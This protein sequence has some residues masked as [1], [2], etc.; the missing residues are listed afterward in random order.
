[1]FIKI[2]NTLIAILYP[3]VIKGY[4]KK[5]LANG[6]ED[7]ARFNERVGRPKMQRPEGKLIWLHG[8]SVGESISM[9]P[10]IQRIL[11][12]YPDAHVMVTTGTVTSADVMSKRLPERAFH[13]FIPIDNPFF[14]TRFIKHWQPNVALWFESELWPAMLSSIKRKNIPLIL[15]NG[16]ISNKSF[17]R[18]QQFD[19]VCKELLSCFTFCLGQSEED[20]YRLQVLGAPNSICLG[21]LKY[22]G[23]PLPIDEKKRDEIV[24]Q[25]GKRTFWLASSTHNDEELRIA[26]VHKRLKEKFPDLLT[27]IAPRHPQRGPEIKEAIEKI[28]LKASL[29]SENE[30]ITSTTDIYIA[31]TIGE[32]GIWYDI[33]KL[34]FIGGSLIPH[35][36]QNFIE[37]S[38]VRDAV[39]VGPHMHNFTDAMNRAKKADAI[40]QVT[41]TEELQEVV[42]QLLENKDLLDAKCS[43]AYNWATS[44]AKV[45]EGIMDKVKGFI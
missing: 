18:W 14:T 42:S 41:D 43:L 31:N 5:R 28:G 10:L 27:L 20:A 25:I 4:I 24:K 44:E 12:T 3:T 16:R 9:L 7:Q 13:Q 6:K 22:A 15:I 17:K 8:A 1:M 23:L 36:G 29:R 19:F 32:M 38:R 2:Y 34:V 37:P 11:D 35:G 26:K 39:V 21:N 45:L 33:A 30:K 40:I